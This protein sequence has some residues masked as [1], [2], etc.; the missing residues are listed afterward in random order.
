LKEPI[1]I[2]ALN[3]LFPKDE[4][5][6]KSGVKISGVTDID[7]A[8]YEIATGFALLIQHKWLIPPETGNESASN[9]EKLAVGVSQAQK[10]QKY[11]R[12]HPEFLHRVLGLEG[13]ENF[14]QIESVVICRGFEHTG[15]MTKGD[16]PIIMEVAFRSL[17]N[18]SGDF[19]ELWSKLNARPDRQGSATKVVDILKTV[20]I[21]EYEFVLPCLGRF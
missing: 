4:Y 9:D 17:V 20:K 3:E 6:T 2:K 7:F 12:D 19:P 14:K 5:R 10:T 8:V 13:A 11:V 21:G 16:T 18:A 1:A 15:F